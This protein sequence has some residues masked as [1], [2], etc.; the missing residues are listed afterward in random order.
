MGKGHPE[1]LSVNLT[2][3]VCTFAKMNGHGSRTIKTHV[4][5]LKNPLMG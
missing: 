2:V 1:V 4:T 3:T 5:H